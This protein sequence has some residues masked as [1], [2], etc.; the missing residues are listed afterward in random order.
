MDLESLG[1]VVLID[2]N[3]ADNLYHRIVLGDCAPD[4]TV[5]DYSS[6]DDALAS[7]PTW[8]TTTASTLVL[9]DLN[10]PGMDGWEFLT[11]YFE[12][13]EGTEAYVAVLS[14]TENPDEIKRAETHGYVDGFVSKPLTEDKLRMLFDAA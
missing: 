2:D 5:L 14:T 7:L 3:G 10:M 13:R 8:A 9:V 6:G 12:Q 4:V 1:V 11:A